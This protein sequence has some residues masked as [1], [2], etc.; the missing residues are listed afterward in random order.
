VTVSA[1]LRERVRRQAEDRCGYCLSAQRYVFAP[2]EIDHIVPTARG[3]TDD[4]D[5]LWLAC[6]MCNGFKSDRMAMVDPY[7]GRVNDNL[8]S[9]IATVG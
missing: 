7:Y 9:T 2:L 8:Q 4:E 1:Q 6:R 5:N 3:G